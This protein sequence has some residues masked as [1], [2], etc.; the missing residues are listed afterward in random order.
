MLKTISPSSPWKDCEQNASDL[1]CTTEDRQP[2][3]CLV[4][5]ALIVKDVSAQGQEPTCSARR[6]ESEHS[7]WQMN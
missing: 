7:V 3:G 5:P 4:A 2:D 1:Y 6:T